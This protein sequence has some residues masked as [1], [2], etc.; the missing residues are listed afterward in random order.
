MGNLSI[1]SQIE[2]T[3]KQ[4]E[5]AEK[6]LKTKKTIA[7]GGGSFGSDDFYGAGL[8]T[9]ADEKDIKETEERLRKANSKLLSLQSE[10]GKILTGRMIGEYGIRKAESKKELK[11]IMTTIK[12]DIDTA[13]EQLKGFMANGK[14]IMNDEALKLMSQVD[15]LK[16]VY[17][18]AQKELNELG[19]IKNKAV[20]KG[21]GKDETTKSEGILKAMGI[22]GELSKEQEASIMSAMST[23]SKIQGLSND[24]A[25]TQFEKDIQRIKDEGNERL[26]LALEQLDKENKLFEIKQKEKIV[27]QKKAK[28]EEERID[29]MTYAVLQSAANA[30][31]NGILSDSDDLLQQI[32]AVALQTAGSKIF[33][34]GL[35]RLWEGGGNMLKFSEP[36]KQ[37]E[38]AEQFAYGL[39]EVGAGLGLGY[40]GK[41]LMPSKEGTSKSTAADDRNKFEA[42]KDSQM[43]VYLYPDEKHYLRS[44]NK[45]LAKVGGQK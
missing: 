29:K 7:S 38:G 43:S 6:L 32:A 17:G 11:A 39:A 21:K 4:S 37:A 12:G 8:E 44:F 30:F 18:V 42:Q 28:E 3:R 23:L 5:E 25:N 34:D 33:A 41:E 26:A 10:A 22:T 24:E 20:G 16:N 19:N 45:S 27:L 1:R 9:I 2:N 36:A 14:F 31:Y 35:T 40:A 13:N 15:A